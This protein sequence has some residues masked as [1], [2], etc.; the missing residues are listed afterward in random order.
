[1]IVSVD[2]SGAITDVTIESGVEPTLDAAAADTVRKWRFKPATR[3]GRP[4]AGTFKVVR[5]FELGD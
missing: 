5:R 4:V 1:M 2:E 3:C